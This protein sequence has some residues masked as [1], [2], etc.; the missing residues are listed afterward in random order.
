MRTNGRQN[1]ESPIEDYLAMTEP[2]PEIWFQTE[3][4]SVE[5]RRKR[6]ITAVEVAEKYSG[7]YF[8]SMSAV[9]LP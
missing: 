1:A 2:F 4:G 6:M 9:L 8:E 3:S 5:E 7:W